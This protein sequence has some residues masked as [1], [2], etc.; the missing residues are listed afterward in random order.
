M[1]KKM[2]KKLSKKRVGLIALALAGLIIGLDLTVISAV[3]P[4]LNIALHAST[5]DMQ[6]FVNAYNLALVAFLVPAGL[7]GDRYG[8]KKMLIVG[9]FIFCIASLACAYA[10]SIGELVAARAALGVGA[11]LV[12]TLSI[13]ILTVLI[14]PEERQKAIGLLI[15]TNMIGISLGPLVGGYLLDH[16]WWGSV[17]LINVPLIL[18]TILTTIWFI[19]ESLSAKSPIL[20]VDGI[21]TSSIGLTVLT[22]G[23]IRAGSDDW[24]NMVTLLA[25]AIGVLLLTAFIVRQSWLARTNRQPLIDL[26]LFSDSSFTWGLILATTATFTLLSLLFSL[27]QYL[28]SVV[29]LSALNTGI[30]IWPLVL[31]LMGGAKVAEI[32]GPKLGPNRTVALGFGLLAT[33]LFMASTTIITTAYGFMFAWLLITGYGI[34]AIIP[35][36]M[37]LSLMALSSER[38]GVG[39]ATMQAFRTI[40]GTIGVAV[41]GTIVSV[42][43]RSGLDLH[44]LPQPVADT[45]QKGVG[46]GMAVARHMP[47]ITQNVTNSYIHASNVMYLTCASIAVTG[48]VLALLVLPKKSPKKETV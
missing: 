42:V 2:I 20:N 26:S 45:I 39:A 9:L 17:F 32:L 22:F 35:A 3:L 4:T 46:Q 16:F 19:T 7:I 12:V 15:V 8:R 5:S 1:I 36:T 37:G 11:A 23:S 43:Y 40:G 21:L 34:G 41:L 28:Q 48:L 31:G 27:P 13:S 14:E 33:G 18:L 10:G 38:S 47:A 24:M 6:W 29:H 44:G 30:R 25:L